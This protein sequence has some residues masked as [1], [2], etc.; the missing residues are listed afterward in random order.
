[1]PNPQVHV[2]IGMVGTL[3][4][5]GIV[6]F[7]YRNKKFFYFIPLLVLL[8]GFVSLIP[9]LP[10]LSPYYPSVFEPLDIDREHK[11]IWNTQIFNI[12]FLHP[13]LDSKFPEKYD[14][15]GLIIT[16]VVYNLAAL[17]YFSVEKK[18]IKR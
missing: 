3:L 15:F 13:Y 10:E 9:D 11:P 18:R 16:L 4:I 14:T 5:I 12:C 1:M 7:F 6:S 8:G 2:A 17:F